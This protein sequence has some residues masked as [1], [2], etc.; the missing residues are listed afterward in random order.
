MEKDKNS[1]ITPELYNSEIKTIKNI[2]IEKFKVLFSD[3]FEQLKEVKNKEEIHIYD[4]GNNSNPK[5]PIIYINNH[6]N[7]TGENP[8]RG[9]EQDNIQFYDITEIY[10]QNKKGKLAI[11]FGN[12]KNLK[13]KEGQVSVKFLCN[14]AINAHVVGFKKIYGYAV[15]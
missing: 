12:N 1:Y 13:T 10:Q 4:I 11:C 2:K 15:L 5:Q 8:L 7:K 3:S 6:I 14:H 9:K